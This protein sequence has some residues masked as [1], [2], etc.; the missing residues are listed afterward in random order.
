MSKSQVKVVLLDFYLTSTKSIPVH[1][2]QNG[3]KFLPAKLRQPREKPINL[4][5]GFVLDHW[6]GIQK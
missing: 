5:L 4:H 6:K 3:R 1:L 2:Q